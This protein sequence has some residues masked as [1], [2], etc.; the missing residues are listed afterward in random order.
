MKSYSDNIK[1]L[2]TGFL[3]MFFLTVAVAQDDNY[4]ELSKNLDVFSNLY[5]QIDLNYVDEIKPGD[6]MKTGIDAMLETLDPY[7]V[8]I[9]ESEIEDYRFMT[10]G[11]YGGIGALIHKQDDQ[12]VISEPYLGSP[13]DKAGLKA[14]DRIIAVNGKSTS[15]KSV[16]DI[17]TILKGQP[18]TEVTLSIQRPGTPQ[19]F[20]K[21]VVRENIKVD[22]IPYYGMLE[23]NIGYVRLSGF[24]QD[25]GNEVRKAFEELK[26]GNTMKGFVLDLR[27]NGGG[28]LHEAVNICNLFVDK[29][30]VIVKTKGKIPQSN[31][32]YKTQFAPIDKEIP[33]VVL[34]DSKSASASEIVA[35]A[36]QDLDRAVVVGQRSYGKGLVQ[37][38]LPLS[39]N[40]QVKIT[41]AKYYIPSGRCI[42]AIDYSHKDEDGIFRKIPDSLISEFKTNKGR[43][44][45]DGGGVD[46][47]ITIEPTKYS[48]LTNNLIR[49]FYIFDY[50][51]LFS[52]QHDS[53]APPADFRV[54]NEI[55]SGFRQY[56]SEKK[57]DYTSKSELDIKSL[58]ESAIKEKFPDEIQLE[59]NSLQTLIETHKKENI[60]EFQDEISGLLKS[61]IVV[62]YY[63]QKGRII[64]GLSED[65]D[66][67]KA[68]EVLLDQKLLTS[69]LNGT[70]IKSN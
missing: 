51:T 39:Y 21:N 54:S 24:T 27:G 14:G 7:T 23:G 44:V 17:S 29:D 67:L 4:F 62:R 15:G 61:E 57:F 16:S 63:Y 28:L 41:V 48:L 53:I 6:L 19:P 1:S 12:A 13:A 69:V 46:P 3:A 32:T 35:G 34:I 10:T 20:D 31:N 11:Q 2:L 38:V 66:I 42:Q 18:G 60:A 56:L 68:R 30:Q 45:Y 22:N 70:Y 50:A 58:K 8:Y 33:L 9:P 43:K 37:N 55:F 59:I 26:A 65:P 25:A 40:A 52:Q 49:D 36:L 47:D 64:S 5:K